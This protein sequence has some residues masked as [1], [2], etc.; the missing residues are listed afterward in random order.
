MT[1]HYTE[2]YAGT[3]EPRH[4][5]IRWEGDRKVYPAGRMMQALCGRRARLHDH[6]Q[7]LIE[8]AD[9]NAFCPKCA[10]AYARERAQTKSE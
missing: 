9:P 6:V 3:P 1:Y 5:H 4:V 8:D 7:P 10:K 2:E